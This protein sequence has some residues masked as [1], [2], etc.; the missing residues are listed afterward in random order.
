[1]VIEKKLIVG[2]TNDET[3]VVTIEEYGLLKPKVFVGRW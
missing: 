3:A 1:M 2:K